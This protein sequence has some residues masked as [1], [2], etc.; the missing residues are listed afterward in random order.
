[1]KRLNFLVLLFVQALL[2]GC[3]SASLSTHVSYQHA[4]LAGKARLTG[5]ITD[6]ATNEAVWAAVVSVEGTGLVSGA[7]YNGHYYFDNVPLGKHTVKAQVIGNSVNV[8][9][10][11]DIK[12]NQI[13]NVNFR[14][15][16]REKAVAK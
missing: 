5:K 4:A 14:V 3:G 2:D 15:E 11:V 7:D 16:T 9:Q 8:S 1:M 10:E 13:V 12:P 6:A